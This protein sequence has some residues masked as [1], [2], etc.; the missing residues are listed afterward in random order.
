[1]DGLRLLSELAQVERHI[2]SG[3]QRIAELRRDDRNT[4]AYVDLLMALLQNQQEHIRT[5]ERIQSELERIPR[6]LL[7]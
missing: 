5:R 7:S 3:E 4:A 2:A 1:M 6:A